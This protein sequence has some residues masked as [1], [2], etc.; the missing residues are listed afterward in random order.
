MDESNIDLESGEDVRLTGNGDS[1]EINWRRVFSSLPFGKFALAAFLALTTVLLTYG[2]TPRKQPFFISDVSLMRPYNTD[3]VPYWLVI[4]IHP[5]LMLAIVG[6]EHTFYSRGRTSATQFA[7]C[8]VLFCF[9]ELIC[10]VW[11]YVFYGFPN[12]LVGRPRPDFLDRCQPTAGLNPAL[13]Y[14]DSVCTNLDK[15]MV[16]HGF[17]SYPSGHTAF[18]ASFAVFAFI[19]FH[20][21]LFRRF[22]FR[23]KTTLARGCNGITQR[24][25]NQ[26]ARLLP[27][28]LPTMLALYVGSTRITDNR[29]HYSDVLAGLLVGGVAGGVS[30][31]SLIAY[32]YE[33]RGAVGN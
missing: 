5:A 20:W 2:F 8:S 3:T 22:G 32:Y 7:W 24:E 17:T 18:T 13:L 33:W 27:C 21:S 19:Y 28:I 26:F 29:H 25:M 11:T 31:A 6:T 12:L 9:G 23:R 4:L 16:R 1:T 15:S 10:F 14:T 30:G